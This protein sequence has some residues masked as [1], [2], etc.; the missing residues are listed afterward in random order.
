[1]KEGERDRRRDTEM[2]EGKEGNNV[3][4]RDNMIYRIRI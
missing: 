1:M 4:S 3:Y 2:E